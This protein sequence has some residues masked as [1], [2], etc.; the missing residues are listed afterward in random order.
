MTDEGVM[1]GLSDRLVLKKDNRRA[2]GQADSSAMTPLEEQP[3]QYSV[4]D[5]LAE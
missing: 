4:A 5:D 3:H 2:I 1:P